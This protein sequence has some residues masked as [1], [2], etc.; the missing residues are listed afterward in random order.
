MYKEGS[1]SLG[2]SLVYVYRGKPA[3]TKSPL[4]SGHNSSY[5]HL[6]LF[7]RSMT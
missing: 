2:E 6:A 3:V 1:V 5:C 4:M 7:V